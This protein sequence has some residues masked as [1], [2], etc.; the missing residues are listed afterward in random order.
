MVLRTMLAGC[1]LLSGTVASAEALERES[2]ISV[3]AGYIEADDDRNAE[4]GSNIRATYGLRLSDRWWLEPTFASSVIE[5]DDP[6]F[7]DYF[8]QTLG[9]DLTYRFSGND[10]FSPF[11]LVG[12]GIS[13]NDVASSRA[14]EFG[15]YGNL[16]VGLLTRE[17]GD[18][19]LRLRAEARYLHDT[20]DE[21]QNDVQLA[22][23]LTFPIGTTRR[24]VVERVEYVEKI[25]EV[26]KKVLVQQADSDADGVVDGVDECPNTIEGLTVNSVGCVEKDQKQSVVLDGVSF[27]VNS[28]R[29]TANAKD[30]LVKTAEGLKGQKDLKVEI[31]GHSD[32]VGAA[33]Y[34]LTLSQQRAEAVR[35]YLLDLGVPASQLVAKGYGETKPVRSNDTPEGRER[36]RR[37]EFNI[38]PQ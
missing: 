6:R 26:E 36:N 20:Y 12:A 1:V 22:V 11:A 13:R 34:N 7:T 30:I 28:N 2:E 8:Q 33:A 9:A 15:G 38:I 21:G 5:T 18:T 32:S 10:Y 4:Y 19:S 17:L 23:G 27:E 3:L 29:L 35:D 37:V 25:V 14:D 16:G 31:A 24:E